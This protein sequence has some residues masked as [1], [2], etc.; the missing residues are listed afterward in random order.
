VLAR[1]IYD[2]RTGIAAAAIFACY[3]SLVAATGL[4]L[5]ETL[6]TFFLCASCL[7]MQ[8]ALSRGGHGW[9]AAVGGVLALGALTRSVLWLFP[10]VLLVF[11][12]AAGPRREVGR[13]FVQ[14]M[15]AI[16]AF[17]LV[18]APWAYRNTKL[19]KTFTA[20][21]VMGGRNF[22]MGNYE[23]TPFNRPWD[24]I[25]MSGEQA[26]HAML[27]KERPEAR[28]VTQGQ[29]D[30]LALK[31]GLQYVKDNPGQTAARDVAKFFHFWQLERELVAGLQQGYWGGASRLGLLAAAAV[32]LGSYVTVLL[33]GIM[34]WSVCWP[35]HWPMHVFLLLVGPGP[36]AASCSRGGVV[37]P[38]G[39][40]GGC[41]WCWS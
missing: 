26:W 21:D 37:R 27:R 34:G 32:I 17:A 40:P 20:V 6:F 39:W 2:E 23:H 3:P 31:Y 35:K 7:L 10:P 41:A 33:S 13:R 9:F 11:L 25:S 38:C 36:R 1:N 22:M 15:T 12:L 30:K 8:R 24:A 5:T 18:I 28:G 29:L 19:Q 16:L 4:V 14:A